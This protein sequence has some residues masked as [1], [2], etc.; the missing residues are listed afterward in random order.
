[1]GHHFRRLLGDGG[2]KLKVLWNVPLG[3]LNE[4]NIFFI[5]RTELDV[6]ATLAPSS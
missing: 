1:L 4:F 3:M 6:S 5:G 2:Q